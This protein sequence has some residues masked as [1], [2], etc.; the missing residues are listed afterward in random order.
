MDE[1]QRRKLQTKRLNEHVK[2]VSTTLNAV[3]LV[4][5]GAGSAASAIGGDFADQLVLDRPQRYIV[6]V[7]SRR[8]PHDQT[9]VG[10]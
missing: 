1:D 8:A 4:V 9:G 7:G 2:P 5:L 3:G 10:R 6:P